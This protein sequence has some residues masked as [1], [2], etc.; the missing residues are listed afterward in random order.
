M[1]RKALLVGIDTYDALPP[2]SACAADAAA[3]LELLGRHEDGEPNYDCKLVTSATVPREQLTRQSIRALLEELFA[4]DDEVLLYFSGH[5]VPT[6][7]GGV[8]CTADA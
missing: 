5:G 2:L 6:I 8:L 1:A 3:M 7:A 4:A